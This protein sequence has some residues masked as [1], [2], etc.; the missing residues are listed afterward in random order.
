MTSICALQLVERGKLTLDDPVHTYIPELKDIKILQTFDKEGKPVE[1][2]HN[3]P[4]TLRMLLTHTSGLTYDA[5]HPKLLA[6]LAY[7]GR[8]HYLRT[9]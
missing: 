9:E 7:H 5:M 6:W 8:D 1:V 4:I 2:Q 3:K